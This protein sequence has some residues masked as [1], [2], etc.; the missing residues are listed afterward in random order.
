MMVSSPCLLMRVSTGLLLV[1][2]GGFGSFS[3]AAEHRDPWLKVN[4]DTTVDEVDGDKKL[5]R[6]L[7]L[8]RL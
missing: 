2:L 3:H 1:S 6:V 7:K 5:K 8:P 4:D